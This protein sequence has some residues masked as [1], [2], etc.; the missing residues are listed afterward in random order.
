MARIRTTKPEF[1]SSEQ[2]VNL[3]IPARLLF[4]GMW[5]FCDDAGTH[6][7]SHITLKA[8]VFPCDNIDISPL[9]DEIERQGLIMRYEVDGKSYWHVTGWHHQKIDKPSYKHPLPDGRIPTSFIK[10]D[11][12]F[13]RYKDIRRVF[14]EYSTNDRRVLDLVREGKGREGEGKGKDC[15]L[16]D[17]RGTGREAPPP[18]P[19]GEPLSIYS[20][21]N[22]D[23]LDD[24]REFTPVKIWVKGGQG[25]VISASMMAEFQNRFPN[26][27][28]QRLCEDFRKFHSS[29]GNKLSRSEVQREL[30]EY[31]LGE[32]IQS[33]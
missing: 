5:N 33:S 10:H 4:K 6:P 19:K 8:V 3:S 31:M 24:P 26:L 30:E 21:T 9:I 16:V 7:A 23:S 13:D 2:I 20:P 18:P 22:T 27:D 29:P 32:Y 25:V 11:Q 17:G 12:P 28:V 15:S 14:D 1:W